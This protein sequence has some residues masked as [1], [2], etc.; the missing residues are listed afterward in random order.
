VI[1]ALTGMWFQFAYRMHGRVPDGEAIDM[2]TA[3][4]LRGLTGHA[5]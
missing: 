3:F 4:S 2:L 1:E 5:R